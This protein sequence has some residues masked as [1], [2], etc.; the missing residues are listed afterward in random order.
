MHYGGQLV[1]LAKLFE[2]CLI[3]VEN[4]IEDSLRGLLGRGPTCS[5]II[6][7]VSAENFISLWIT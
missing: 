5:C 4:P 6:T 3:A 7:K 1:Y 2:Q